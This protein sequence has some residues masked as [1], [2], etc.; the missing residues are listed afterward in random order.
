MKNSIEQWVHYTENT[1][2]KEE[3]T[4]WKSNCPAGAEILNESLEYMKN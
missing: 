1:K 4:K 2:G 3:L